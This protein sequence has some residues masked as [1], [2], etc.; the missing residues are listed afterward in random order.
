MSKVVLVT[1]QVSYKKEKFPKIFH[2][3]DKF[4]TFLINIMLSIPEIS[5][6]KAAQSR[7]SLTKKVKDLVKLHYNKKQSE[8]NHRPGEPPPPPPN[9]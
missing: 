1:F 8:Y 5:G 2:P 7:A 3:D 6:G 9:L 4:I